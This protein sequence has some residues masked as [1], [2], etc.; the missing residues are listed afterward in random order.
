VEPGKK[1]TPDKTQTRKKSASQEDAL[2]KNPL[3]P[4]SKR[5][6][7]YYE[8]FIN[9]FDLCFCQGKFPEGTREKDKM[10]S[11]KK[12]LVLFGRA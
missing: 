9:F 6:F 5:N 3:K 2:F 10:W 8:N 11:L 12:D 4:P 7:L 1:A